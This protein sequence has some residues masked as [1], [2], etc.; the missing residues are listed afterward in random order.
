M[1]AQWQR[2]EEQSRKQTEEAGVTIVGTIDRKPFEDATQPLRD[3]LRADPRFRS[4]I[5][6]IGAV[7]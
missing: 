6:R 3:R 5:E 2:W 1:R 4:L 7:Q